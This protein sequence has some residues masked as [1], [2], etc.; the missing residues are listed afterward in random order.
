MVSRPDTHFHVILVRYNTAMIELV[1]VTKRYDDTIVVDRLNL[2]IERGE[3]V[4]MIGHNGA[5]KSTTM[6]MIAGLVEPT[7]G[8]VRVMGHDMQKES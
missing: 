6:K 8:Q 7:A 2:Q 4:G 5:G 3:I 1:D